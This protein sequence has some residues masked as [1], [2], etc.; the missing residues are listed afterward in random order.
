MLFPIYYLPAVF[1]GNNASLYSPGNS[2]EMETVMT[3][4]IQEKFRDIIRGQLERFPLAQSLDLY[5]LVYQAAMG[6]AHATGDIQAIRSRLRAEMS[7]AGSSNGEPLVDIICPFGRIARV[8]LRPFGRGGFDL[9]HLAEAFT[10]TAD[11]FPGSGDSLEQYCRWLVQIKDEGLLPSSM[12]DIDDVLEQFRSTGFE[13]THHSEVYRINYAPS[14][15]VVA[16]EL[17]G[18]LIGDQKRGSY[19]DHR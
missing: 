10:A 8:N 2:T 11:E 4:S 19:P 17:I 15:R 7:I 1:P 3:D 13:S 14:Y 9:L 12:T 5:K 6:S 16:T 18:D